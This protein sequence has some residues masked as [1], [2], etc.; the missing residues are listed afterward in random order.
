M[1]DELYPIPMRMNLIKVHGGKR[2][3]PFSFERS[4]HLSS[5]SRSCL[6]SLIPYPW[7]TGGYVKAPPTKPEA[8]L[9]V[10]LKWVLPETSA[11]ALFVSSSRRNPLCLER[12]WGLSGPWERVLQKVTRD[13]SVV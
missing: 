5:P 4:S 12:A 2:S 1:I 8:Q 7:W 3:R 9:G 11:A 13:H 10:L 6:G